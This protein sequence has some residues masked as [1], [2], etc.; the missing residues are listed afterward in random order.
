MRCIRKDIG[1]FM[2]EEKKTTRKRNSLSKTELI[3]M[4]AEK[5]ERIVELQQELEKTH[6]NADDL[7]NE[8][9]VSKRE[10]EKAV[11]NFKTIENSKFW[12]MTKPARAVLDWVKEIDIP[13]NPVYYAHMTGK[14]VS[15]VKEQGPTFAY[16]KIKSRLTEAPSYGRW[17]KKNKVTEEELEAQRQ[18]HFDKNITFSIVV[19]LYNTPEDF[20]KEMIDSVCGQTYGRWQLCMADGSDDEHK[21]VEAI[22]KQYSQADDRI[23]YKKLEENLGIAGNTNAC[24]EMATGNY[25]ALF[26][27]DDILHPSALYEMMKVICEK[28]ADIVYTDE[29]VFIS[30][31]LNKIKTIHFKPDY[32]PDNLK[33]NNYICHFTAFK[34][35]LLE[36]TG[37][38][39]RECDG[40]QDHDL[41]LRLTEKATTIEHIPKVL[42]YWRA[43]PKSVAMSNSAKGYASEGGKKAVSDSIERMGYSAEVTSSRAIDSIYRIKYELKDRPLVSIVIPTYDNAESLN[44]CI[45]SIKKKSTYTNYEIIVADGSGKEKRNKVSLVN[46][47]VKE[48]VSGDYIILLSDSAEIITSSWIEEMLMYAQRKDVGAVGALLFNHNDT[49]RSAGFILGRGGTA[50]PAFCGL[51]WRDFGYMGRLCY[52]Q[53]LSAV[54]DDCLMIRKDIWNKMQGMDESYGESYGDIDLCMRIRKAGFLIVWT[55]YAELYIKNDNIQDSE[56]AS[57]SLFRLR[58]ANELSQG[59]PYYNSNFTLDSKRRDFTVE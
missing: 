49:V 36:Q 22:C 42:Y 35:S 11:D 26:D 15:T 13:V 54:S 14:V 32:A 17:M 21:Y 18:T 23:K 41:I 52:S 20:L 55:P 8:L 40:S 34:H 44:R 43:H 25:V 51:S 3:E 4:L 10:I 29:L 1:A 6:I 48:K 45:E 38:F 16:R 7:R 50:A 47:A 9:E 53:N 24:L 33:A 27:H 59:D 46:S 12:K 58:W 56:S 57:Q 28:D 19:P 5:D 39:R 30:P 37:G 31:K 2:S